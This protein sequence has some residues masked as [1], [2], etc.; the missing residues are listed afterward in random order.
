MAPRHTTDMDVGS[1][2]SA[3]ARYRPVH[4][5]N[6]NVKLHVKLLDDFT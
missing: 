6:L 1:V 2:N 3:G 5:F 4:Q